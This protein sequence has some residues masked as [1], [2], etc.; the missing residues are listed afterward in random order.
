MQIV[1]TIIPIFIVIV[2]GWG[3]QR[4]GFIPP[5][6][7]GPANRLV[8]YVAIPAMIFRSISRS[9]LLDWFNPLMIAIT[10]VSAA[11]VYSIAW[12]LS[13]MICTERAQVGTFIQSCGHG[14]LGYIGLAVAYYFLGDTGL[15]Y[16]S[17]VAGFLMIVQNA[18]SI[19]ALEAYAPKAQKT[20]SIVILAGKIL[21]NPVI[22]AAAIGMVFSA[23]QI[24]LPMILQRSL[25]II[26]G[27]ALP[28]A[29]LL[30]G[31]SLSFG[32]ARTHWQVVIGAAVI[33]LICLPGIGWILYTF[34]AVRVDDFLP[35]LIL[36]GSPTATVAYVMSKEMDGDHELA[37]ATISVSTLMSALTYTLWLKL[38]TG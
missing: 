33:K 35:G 15:V 28:T 11:A 8:F 2:L 18:L 20:H 23:L 3:I 38:A 14:N 36:L 9:A 19:L 30:I 24:P 25:D 29:L 13:R 21:A 31:A 7:L 26:K 37:V 34:C 6:F 4:R 1:T 22:V 16:A 12:M 32:H 10:L 17:V 27:M 5:E